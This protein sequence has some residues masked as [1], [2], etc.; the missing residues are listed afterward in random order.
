M[1]GYAY[2]CSYKYREINRRGVIRTG[3]NLQQQPNSYTNRNDAIISP[4][5]S[6]RRNEF[7]DRQD[8]DHIILIN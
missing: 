3:Q 1:L 4:T 8:S 2:D 7:I 6:M 5:A